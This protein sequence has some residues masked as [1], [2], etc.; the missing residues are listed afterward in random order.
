[1][2][3]G[4]ARPRGRAPRHP[5]RGRAEAP[6]GVRRPAAGRA[7]GCRPTGAPDAG[8]LLSAADDDGLCRVPRRRAGSGRRV[9]PV[10]RETAGRPLCVRPWVSNARTPR[11]GPSPVSPRTPRPPGR[12]TDPTARAAGAA[13]P[14]RADHTVGAGTPVPGGTRSD[15]GSS[16]AVLWSYRCDN[17]YASAVTHTCA[18]SPGRRNG[19]GRTGSGPHAGVTRGPEGG[20]GEAR[21]APAPGPPA[22]LSP[23]RSSRAG[24]PWS[25]RVAFGGWTQLV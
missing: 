15:W 17:P 22:R 20:T 12:S 13:R 21:G 9:G 1:M 16:A 2:R 24:V 14:A 11:T 5:Q 3:Q 4:P 19:V 7:P 25:M 23:D 18:P 8:H 6:A 10:R